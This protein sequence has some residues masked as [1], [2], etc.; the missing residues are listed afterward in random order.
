MGGGG[1]ATYRERIVRGWRLGYIQ[2]ENST[3]V[4]AGREE[5]STRIHT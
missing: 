4:E 2:R 3:G 1:W 5:V